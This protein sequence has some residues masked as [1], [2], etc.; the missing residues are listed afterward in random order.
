MHACVCVHVCVCACVYMCA[1]MCITI[2]VC[3]RSRALASTAM[4][5]SMDSC[6]CHQLQWFFYFF[7][8]CQTSPHTHVKLLKDPVVYCLWIFRF[9]SLEFR[10]HFSFF[11]KCWT[12]SWTLHKRTS[13]RLSDA[14]KVCDSMW[15]PV[16]V[17]W[18][19]YHW[20]CTVWYWEVVL[21]NAAI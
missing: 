16:C 15:V 13:A 7:I 14:E 21:R 2:H 10:S 5:S 6:V 11:S 3:S 20:I 12:W 9:Q 18:E 1:C 4:A 8:F 19:S 17:F